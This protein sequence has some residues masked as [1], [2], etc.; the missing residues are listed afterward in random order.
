MPA[1][2]PNLAN[3][4]IST[5]F[6]SS[7]IACAVI[8]GLTA[9]RSL[10][11]LPILK[12]EPHRPV[13]WQA[14]DLSIVL[15]V[16]VAWQTV[17]ILLLKTYLGPTFTEPP[18][19]YD[20]SKAS[21]AHVVLQILS[22][23][24]PWMLLSCV[25]AAVLVAPVVEEFL[26]RVLLQGYLEASQR[27]WRKLLPTLRLLMPGTLGPILLT[28]ILFARMHFRVDTPKLNVWFLTALLA[29][30]AVASLLTLVCAVAVL[31]LRAGATDADLGW[32]SETFL[33]DLRLGLIAFLAIAAPS[34]P[35]RLV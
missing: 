24:N 33:A 29:G 28:S 22:A 2:E 34:T 14:L 32:V 8:W 7:L 9:R 1:T 16:Y 3:L 21:S 20:V 27:R 4:L 12:Y 31:R 25:I 35:F 19:M 13:P 17:A 23:N 5:A 18:V 6:L 15:A 30:N 10:R 11:G 26:F